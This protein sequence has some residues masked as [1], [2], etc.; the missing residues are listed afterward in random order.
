M[1]GCWQI[2]S[3]CSSNLIG[4]GRLHLGAEVSSALEF[5]MGQGTWTGLGVDRQYMARHY[6]EHEDAQ[7]AYLPVMQGV[8]AGQMVWEN[9]G[10]L[11]SEVVAPRRIERES[12]DR[13]EAPLGEVIDRRGRDYC[14]DYASVEACL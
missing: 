3:C 5:H 6:S 4:D 7:Q 14:E 1:G 8:V 9:Y 12:F 11:E 13:F 2:A 10:R